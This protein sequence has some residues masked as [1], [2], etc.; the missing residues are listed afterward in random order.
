M[1]RFKTT[2]R[3]FIETAALATAALTAPPFIRRSHAA[4]KLTVALWDHWVPASN[5]VQK[6]LMMD[7]AAKNKVDL[8]VDFV[9]SQGNSNT[10]MAVAESRAKEGHDVFMLPQ[11][12][13]SI[14]RDS[15]EPLDDIAAEMQKAYGKYSLVAE[16]ACKI[17]GVWR[18]VPAPTGSH[19][20]PMVSRLDFFQKHCGVD[21]QKVFPTDVKQRD[22]KLVD[23]W[24]YDNFLVYAEKLHK[25][26]VPFGNPI[27]QTS[28]TNSWLGPLFKSFGSEL[29]N[30]SGKITVNSDGT[31][32]ALEYMKKLTQFMP[33]E[34][35][36]WDDAGNNLHII[37]GR[38]ACIQNPPSA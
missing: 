17:K 25:A 28:D 11:Q 29:V 24:N 27:G 8:S 5:D 6:K 1:K 15:L 31:R 18:A 36:S 13:P 10:L 2:R 21:L 12:Y 3:Q 38:G 4:G 37:S 30:E 33:P 19:S 22:K 35:Y 32:A 14:L 9:T 16:Y 23:A 34:I 7:W 26:G 20:Y